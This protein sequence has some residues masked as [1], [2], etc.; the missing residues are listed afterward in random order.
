MVSSSRISKLLRGHVCFPNLPLVYNAELRF[1]P[2][3]RPNSVLSTLVLRTLTSFV[4]P[5]TLHAQVKAR[6]LLRP[7]TSLRTEVRMSPT[8]CFCLTLC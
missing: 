5:T 4:E 2:T 8:W 7:T 6:V 1:Q 3:Y